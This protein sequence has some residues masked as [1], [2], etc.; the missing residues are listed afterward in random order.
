M[1][2][3]KLIRKHSF[4]DIRVFEKEAISL[5]KLGY[6]VTIVA[7]KTNGAVFEPNLKRIKDPTFNQDQFE[8]KGIKF[9]T[10][11][12]KNMYDPHIGKMVNNLEMDTQNYFVDKLYERALA[13]EAD[14]YHAHELHTLYEAV[15]IKKVLRKKGKN[16]KVIYDAHELEQNSKLLRL[17]MK[18]VDHLITVSDSIKNIYQRRYP[19]VPVTVI[20]NSPL[21][22]QELPKDEHFQ[23][24]FVI[25]YE[26]VVQY[27]K[28]NPKKIL[29]I[30]DLCKNSMKNFRFDIIGYIDPTISYN[31]KKLI[32]GHPAIH[33]KWVE[34]ENLPKELNQVHAGYIYFDIRNI[35]K[36]YALPNKFFSFLNNG[37]PVVVNRAMDM[38][39]IIEKHQCGIVIDKDDP[40]AEEYVEQFL[41]LYK[42]R[43]MLARMSK[44]AREAM[45]NHYCL[46]KMEER[47]AAI[48]KGLK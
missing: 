27:Q 37:I 5:K 43:K 48:Y 24:Y 36:K 21:Y 11:D 1:K 3:C 45:K 7:G 33:C 15:Q 34:Y 9:L 30:A 40:T 4:K 14:I 46:E 16:V 41:R 18:E 42:D 25:A 32:S 13:V 19:S 6:D 26:G 28:G 29:Q 31:E 35:N 23:H 8:Y 44:N 20:Y 17:L 39:N 10:Y 2:V 47:L 22:Q 38:K 12:I